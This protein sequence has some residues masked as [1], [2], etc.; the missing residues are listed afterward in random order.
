M[1]QDISLEQFDFLSSLFS[2]ALKYQ[3]EE[4]YALAQQ[5]YEQVLGAIP[6]HVDSLHYLGLVKYKLGKS[7]DAI[8]L[9]RKA[10]LQSEKTAPSADSAEIY[11]NL[12]VV[13]KDHQEFQQ[14]KDAYIHSVTIN[15]RHILAHANLAVLTWRLIEPEVC[16]K[17][18]RI[19][20]ELNPIFS[21]RLGDY[22]NAL[23]ELNAQ[24]EILAFRHRILK[25]DFASAPGTDVIAINARPEDHIIPY[26]L[27]Y[28]A[29]ASPEVIASMHFKWGCNATLL[30]SGRMR[31]DLVAKDKAKKEHQKLC[32]AYVSADF[33]EHAVARFLEP[34]LENHDK[35]KFEIIAYANNKIVDQVTLR[36]KQ[37]FDEWN[38]VSELDDDAFCHLVVKDK[39]DILVDLAGHSKGNRLLAFARKPAPVQISYLGY[40]N[41]T[42]LPTMDYRIT[43]GISDPQGK[44]DLY[45]SES[46]LRLMG[47]FLCYRPELNSPAVK[48]LPAIKNGNIT[49]GCFNNSMKINVETIQTWSEI[50]QALPFSRLLLR[51]K[52]FAEEQSRRRLLQQF[53][54]LG[55]AEDRL[56]L[57]P[58]VDTNFDALNLYNRMD[59]ALDTFP[60]NGTTTTC[61]S[62]WMGVP[63]ITLA[64]K[65]HVSRVSLSIL[66]TLDLDG[67]V[68]Y[69]RADYMST[70]I[71][72]AS[73]LTALSRLRESLRQRMRDSELTNGKHFTEKLEAKYLAISNVR[74]LRIY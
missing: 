21:T 73:D 63:V 51:G 74:S 49:F 1:T 35:T 12:G 42:G 43:D 38:E 50:L 31:R 60:Y 25:L 24:P 32:I 57:Y 40:P 41:T 26:L 33:R 68:T 19:A 20:G 10:A 48:P 30:N 8:E 15:P 18:H 69:S 4:Q 71:K 54:D 64:G 59:I 52:I 7:N 44:T 17:H 16:E 55:I 67:L 34:I 6:N 61:E 53:Y 3:S 47:C 70:A 62:L 13:Y 2:R 46:L 11:Y 56:T 22:Y 5:Y 36:L 45:Y 9:L 65:T 23:S 58:Y 14:A 66:K 28:D 29:K 39:V 27:N 72:L 37:Y